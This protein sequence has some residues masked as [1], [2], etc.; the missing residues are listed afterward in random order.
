MQTFIKIMKPF[1]ASLLSF[2]LV[3][4]LTMIVKAYYEVVIFI[5]NL[6]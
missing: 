2:V 3:A 4:L 1:G 6:V 5:W